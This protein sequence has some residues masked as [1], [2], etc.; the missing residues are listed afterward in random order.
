M[1]NGLFLVMLKAF[2]LM[3]Y[4]QRFVNLYSICEFHYFEKDFQSTIA[5]TYS[6][7]D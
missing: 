1:P 4:L 3:F 2:D 5:T 7:N 6:S